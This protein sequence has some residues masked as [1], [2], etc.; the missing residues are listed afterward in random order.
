MAVYGEYW[1]VQWRP[2]ALYWAQRVAGHDNPVAEGECPDWESL[3]ATA[4]CT[5]GTV[6][7]R[8]QGPDSHGEYSDPKSASF[9]DCSAICP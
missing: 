3:P 5:S 8:R 2:G 9:S 7:A 1:W 4:G 6:R